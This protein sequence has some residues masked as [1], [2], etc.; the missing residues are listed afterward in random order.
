MTPDNWC[1]VKCSEDL[2]KVFA[3]WYG[4]YLEGESWKLNS[5]IKRFEEDDEEYRFYGYSGSCY[6]CRKS[7]YKLNLYGLS[8]I[9]T[10]NKQ[11]K[12]S[13]F[14]ELEILDEN[15]WKTCINSIG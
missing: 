3:T 14:S 2:Y 12:E 5:G 10:L 1:I 8:V 7:R 4:G 11:L 9:E 6:H 13:N 15:G